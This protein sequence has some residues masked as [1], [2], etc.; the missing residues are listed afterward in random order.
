MLT[1]NLYKHK[2]YHDLYK[3]KPYHDPSSCHY[4]NL[5]QWR[6]LLV[7]HLGYIWRTG[8]SYTLLFSEAV[9]V[10]KYSISSVL[11]QV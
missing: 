1:E 7:S 4:W 6:R 11:V 3:H 8:W 10:Q 5:S 2:P 9:L